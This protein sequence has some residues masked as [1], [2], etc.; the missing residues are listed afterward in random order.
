M[1]VQMIGPMPNRKND[2]DTSTARGQSSV[3]TM[4]VATDTI[5]PNRM[6]P[7]CSSYLRDAKV[8]R[9]PRGVTPR[10]FLVIPIFLHR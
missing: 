9:S 5:G 1:M 7:V 2:A 10:F 4:V 3:A 6:A 8:W